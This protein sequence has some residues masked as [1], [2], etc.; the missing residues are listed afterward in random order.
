MDRNDRHA[1]LAAM[2][3]FATDEPPQSTAADTLAFAVF[4]GERVNV[5]PLQALL[6]SGEAKQKAGSLGLTHSDGRRLLL[7]GLGPRADFDS[8]GARVA[9]AQVA[10]R[11]SELGARHLAPGHCRRARTPGSRARSSKERFSP[12]TDS[13]A[14]CPGATVS[15]RKLSRR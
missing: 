12:S 8:E 13:T 3:I 5:E 14:T 15:R 7:A 6:D 4:D 10:K 11:A 9:A 2:E 1:I